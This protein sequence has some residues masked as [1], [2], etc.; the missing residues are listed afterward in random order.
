VTG[1][2]RAVGALL[3]LAVGDAVGTTL[4]FRSPGTFEPIT[5]MVGGGPFHLPAGAWTDDTSMAMC[6]AE[7]IADT[8]GMDLTDQLRRYVA[9][10]R[11]GYWS[12]TGRCFDIGGTTSRQLS[13]FERTGDAVDPHVDDE[14]AANE[15]LNDE[16]VRI[17]NRGEVA[18]DL[19]GWVLKDTSAS[20]RY[21]FPDGFVLEAG[22]D[23]TV[24]TGCGADTATD[25][26]W[27]N[28]GSAVWNNSKAGGQ[29]SAALPCS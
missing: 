27:C 2:D 10:R 23:V 29:A 7:S 26:H 17:R 13:R 20:H 6:L 24:R 18:V 21:T 19:G 15:N 1:E 3:G 5:D 9:W 25:L 16:W 28:G 11:D 4:E 14:Q 8:G 12:S 22:A